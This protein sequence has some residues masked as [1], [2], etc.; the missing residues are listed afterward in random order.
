[1]ETALEQVTRLELRTLTY[2][3]N[4]PRTQYQEGYLE[5]VREARRAIQREQLHEKIRRLG[6][7][8]MKLNEKSNSSAIPTEAERSSS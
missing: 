7:K 6:Q 5:G 4:A 8:L 2:Y 1:M 3:G